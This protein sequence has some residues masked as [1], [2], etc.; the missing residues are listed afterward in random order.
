M[1]LPKLIFQFPATPVE[2]R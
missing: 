1:K 2:S